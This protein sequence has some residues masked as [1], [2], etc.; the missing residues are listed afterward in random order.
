MSAADLEAAVGTVSPL[1]DKALVANTW[2]ARR[3]MDTALRAVDC[4]SGG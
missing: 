2:E 1:A 3:R 4:R